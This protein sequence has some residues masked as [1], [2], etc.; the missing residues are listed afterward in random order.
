MCFDA[1]QTHK[2]L[3]KEALR[4]QK[5]KKS[6]SLRP[7]WGITLKQ[8]AV[9]YYHING[10]N[11]PQ[12]VAFQWSESFLSAHFFRWGLI[13]RWVNSAEKAAQL[14]Q[15]T[16]NARGETIFEKPSFRDAAKH[17]RIV[18]PLDGFYE[19]HHKN[20][21]KIPHFIQ[22]A[23]KRRLMVAAI[24]SEWLNTHSETVYTF[25]IVT[26]EGNDT[27]AHIHNNPKLKGPRMPLL[28]DDENLMTWLT[29]PPSLAQ[30]II[31]PNHKIALNY[32]PVR[33]LRGKLYLGNCPEIQQE[34]QYPETY[35]PPTLFG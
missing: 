22:A 29:A 3:H 10:F 13:P 30:E 18:V 35:D 1:A 7:D 6:V 20:G 5:N 24:A 27:M 19:H 17:R 21:K 11:H 23:D 15:K 26:C 33:P 32:Y 9:N 2:N 14:A 16:L 25:S 28:L 31:K 4:F 34:Y 8:K 12:L